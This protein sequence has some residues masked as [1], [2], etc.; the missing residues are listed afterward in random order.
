MVDAR[1]RKP[2]VAFLGLV[3]LALTAG[4]LLGF[5]PPWGVGRPI[6]ASEHGGIENL[7]LVPFPEGPNSPL[8]EDPPA[9]ASSVSLSIVEG[10]IPDPLPAPRWQG[11]ACGGG[12]DLVVTFVDGETVSYGPCKKP[13]SIE[14]LRE[15][16]LAVLDA[17]GA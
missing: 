8:F 14:R 2:I 11:V 9:P 6:S 5:G 3:I 12:G 16:M 13:A 10:Y 7:Q 1:M 15:R 4:W 17:Q